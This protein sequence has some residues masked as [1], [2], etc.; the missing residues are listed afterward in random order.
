MSITR[1]MGEVEG[2]IEVKI[3]KSNWGKLRIK[4]RVKILVGAI[5]MLGLCG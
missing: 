4:L 2:Q 5:H 3:Y 1:A